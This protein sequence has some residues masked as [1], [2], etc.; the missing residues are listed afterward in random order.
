MHD[1]CADGLKVMFHLK[2][3]ELVFWGRISSSNSLSWGMSHCRL[4]RSYINTPFGLLGV[5]VERVVKRRVGL[6]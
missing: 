5:H 1:L 3:I 2:I 6:Y 4:P